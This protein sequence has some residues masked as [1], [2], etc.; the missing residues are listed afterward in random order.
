MATGNQYFNPSNP[1]YSGNVQRS[2][3]KKQNEES[4]Q[5][6]RRLVQAYNA[7]PSSFNDV[8]A[9]Q[10][11]LIAK[12]IGLPFNREVKP[13]ANLLYG[14][15]EG[16]SLGFAPDS[17]R[18][19]ERG[20]SVYGRSG[21]NK[22]FSGAGMVVGGLGGLRIGTG[23]L[24]LAGKGATAA[25]SKILS[26]VQP[27]AASAYSTAGRG[28]AAASS[29]ARS[30]ASAASQYA[31]G[32]RQGFQGTPNI[33]APM[34]ES[35]GANLGSMVKSGVVYATPAAKAAAA[36]ARS[37]WNAT[38]LYGGQLIGRVRSGLSSYVG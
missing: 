15:A 13:I 6:M 24:G 33:G 8:E 20:E 21:T 29:A 32:V 1:G 25:G 27:Y 34:F 12:T 14:A 23:L 17:W 2:L 38:N 22:F 7:D 16:L 4:Y 36:Q 35:A 9:E 26:G 11:A 18:P 10:I 30:G 5:K 3:T 19:T 31:S 28:A 37:A